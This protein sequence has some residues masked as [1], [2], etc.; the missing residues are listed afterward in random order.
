MKR[1]SFLSAAVAGTVLFAANGWAVNPAT[2]PATNTSVP[3]PTDPYANPLGY[4]PIP[5]LIPAGDPRLRTD[6]I[7]IPG[8]SSDFSASVSGTTRINPLVIPNTGTNPTTQAQRW[9][10]GVYSKDTD[11]GVR[12]VQVVPNSAAARAGLETNDVIVCVAGYQVGYVNGVPY[13]CGRE[14]ER[15]CDADGWVTML[16]QNN[17]NGQLL[18]MPIQLE[19][20][21][22]GIDGTITYRENYSLPHGSVAT[23]E[24]REVLRPG[25]PPVTLARQTVS[26]IRQIPI[27]YTID[28]DPSQIDPRRSYVLHATITAGNQ[29]LFTTRQAVPVLTSGSSKNIPLI[30]EAST[31]SQPGNP[32]VTRDQQIEQLVALYRAY[33]QRDPRSS[34]VAVWQSHFDRGNTLYDA[35]AQL[36]SMNEFY[37]RCDAN[38]VTYI[39]Q[40]HQQILNKQPSNEELT[41]WLSRME[42]HNH[43]RPEVAREFLAAVGVQR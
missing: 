33:L 25:A 28:Y 24:L 3:Q 41:Y 32:Y 36:L 18:A 14:F 7:S 43:L 2:R 1:I 39:K 8:S 13:D 23:V 4:N 27:P 6:L 10:L 35:Q 42:V 19:R 21:Y 29:T 15:N 37:N 12:I 17:R 34:E 40:L 5:G 20:R 38:D 11:T 22:Q 26:P 31:S 30:V 9:K 16:V